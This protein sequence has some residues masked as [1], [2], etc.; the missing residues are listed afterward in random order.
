MNLG[1]GGKMSKGF[2][3]DEQKQFIMFKYPN[4]IKVI[5]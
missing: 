2:I 1:I 5:T 3:K 4:Q